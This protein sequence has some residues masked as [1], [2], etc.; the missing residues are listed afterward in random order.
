MDSLTSD[1][2]PPSP[3]ESDITPSSFHVAH[4]ATD[5]KAVLQ[6]MEIMGS[7]PPMESEPS[8]VCGSAPILYEDDVRPIGHGDAPEL[9]P[10]PVG[11]PLPPT[12]VS[13]S[14]G[15]AAALEYYDHD[16]FNVEPDPQP[17]APPF[18]AG[19]SFLPSAPPEAETQPL[20]SAPPEIADPDDDPTADARLPRELSGSSVDTGRPGP[21]RPEPLPQYRP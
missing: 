6:Q 8:D 11:F 16:D 12:V 15:K 20:P 2:P 18:E 10:S 13:S 3:L 17:S 5:D 9:V 4:V 1:S 19:D 14:K 7:R 21:S